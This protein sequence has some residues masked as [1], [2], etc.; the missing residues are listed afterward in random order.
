MDLLELTIRRLEEWLRDCSQKL[1]KAREVAQNAER[2]VDD[3]REKVRVVSNALASVKT[4]FE[5][6][7]EEEP[8]T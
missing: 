3:L 7:T 8:N 1:D 4:I 2:K 6:Y 5:N